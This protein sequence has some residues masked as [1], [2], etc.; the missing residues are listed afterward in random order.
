MAATTEGDGNVA[1]GLLPGGRYATVTHVGHPKELVVAT[2]ELL[3]W[4]AAQGLKWDVSPGT[5]GDQ[6]G[7]R[8]E[9]TSP[10]PAG[11]LI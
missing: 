6:W 9:I 4:G 3:D 1:S 11:S 8:L 2:G 7:C 5:Q 10:T